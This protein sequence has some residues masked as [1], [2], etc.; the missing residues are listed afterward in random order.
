MLNQM[1]RKL[2]LIAKQTDNLEYIHGQGENEEEIKKNKEA[3]F[4]SVKYFYLT[5]KGVWQAGQAKCHKAKSHQILIEFLSPQAND[6]AVAVVA[7]PFDVPYAEQRGHQSDAGSTVAFAP[8]K[9]MKL[10][11]GIDQS[12]TIQEKNKEKNISPSSEKQNAIGSIV[13]PQETSSCNHA[14]MVQ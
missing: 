9:R 2:N 11:S 3:K 10:S 12:L 4:K 14:Q 8:S 7:N 6:A 5:P 13:E 1:V